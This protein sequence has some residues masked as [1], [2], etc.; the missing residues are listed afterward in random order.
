MVFLR[1]TRNPD[2]FFNAD[3]ETVRLAKQLRK[4]M[5]GPEKILWEKLRNRKICRFKFRRQHP[6]WIY[7]A[8]FY[9]PELMIAIEIDGPI[10]LSGEKKEQDRN[11]DTELNRFGIKTVRFSNNEII[12]KPDEV[13]NKIEKI[14]AE[15]TSENVIPARPSPPRRGGQGGEV[16]GTSDLI[17]SRNCLRKQSVLFNIQC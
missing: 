14:I 4:I 17:P 11:R 9:C 13:I 8:D 5:T 6:V 10:H 3:Q 1:K 2:Y 16:T 12:H 7:I 15:R